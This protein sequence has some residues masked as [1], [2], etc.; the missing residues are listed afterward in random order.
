MNPRSPAQVAAI[1][2]L[3]PK[4]L[5]QDRLRGKGFPFTT[6]G[7]R[8]PYDLDQIEEIMKA[9]AGQVLSGQGHEEADD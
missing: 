4:K 1:L 9:R 7:R 2:G 3:S 5:R 6:E 8:I